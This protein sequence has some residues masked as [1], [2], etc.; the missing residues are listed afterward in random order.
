M[1]DSPYPY[2]YPCPYPQDEVEASAGIFIDLLTNANTG[3][4]PGTGLP[5]TVCGPSVSVVPNEFERDC[6]GLAAAAINAPNQV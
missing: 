3:T 5:Y 6:D 1:V 2:P 4:T